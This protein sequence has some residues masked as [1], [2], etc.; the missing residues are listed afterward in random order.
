MIISLIHNKGGVGKSTLAL[1]LS[2]ILKADLLVD[3][4]N[5]NSTTQLLN[6]RNKELFKLNVATPKDTNSFIEL[7]KDKSIVVVDTAGN[8]T[9]LNRT[10]LAYSDV[11]ITPVSDSPMELI[12]LRSFANVIDDVSK[13]LNHKITAYVLVNRIS[14]RKKNF[15]DLQTFIE[16][17]NCYK[18]MNTKIPTHSYVKDSTAL[19]LAVT[20]Y[21]K[22]SQSAKA[23]NN[24]ADEIIKLSEIANG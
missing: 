18:M 24:L 17:N 2:V 22:Y 5:I 8:D 14:S 9:N 1:N 16:A 10:V 15:K 23:M 7:V 21:K 20:E 13:I 11:V 4:D 19:C 3:L 6:I 12:G